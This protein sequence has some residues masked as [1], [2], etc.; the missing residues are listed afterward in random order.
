ME[1]YIDLHIHSCFSDGIYRPADIV[2][3]AARRGLKAIAITDHDSVEGVDEA[4]EAGLRSG[5]EVVPAVEFSIAYKHY[6]DIHLLGYFIDYRDGELGRKLADFRRRRDDRA[7]AIIDRINARLVKEKK[8]EITYDDIRAISRGCISRLH[9][10]ETLVRK[11]ASATVQDAFKM[12][13]IPYDVPKQYFPLE[14]A[15]DEIRR[16]NG[17]SVLAHPPSIT[18]DRRLMKS[19]ILEWKKMGLDGIE[20]FNN[21]CFKD[22]MIFY[23]SLAREHGMLMTGGSDF[24]GFEDDVEIGIGR[25]GLSVAYHL[26]HIMKDVAGKK[27]GV[28]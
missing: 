9:I 5:V 23:E 14:E 21:L 6:R 12:Y 13:L 10:A 18:N 27:G 8:T 3:M 2:A 25:G 22:D 1:H 28:A 7:R 16:L 11:G 26:L 4:V 17:I 24:H 15:L 19:L 20:V